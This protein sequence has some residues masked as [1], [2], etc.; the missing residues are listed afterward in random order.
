MR[1]STFQQE[2]GMYF[3]L[4]DTHDNAMSDQRLE[5][6]APADGDSNSWWHLPPGR[7]TFRQRILAI[8]SAPTPRRRSQAAARADAR[9]RR[10]D[11]ELVA[12]SSGTQRVTS[13][14]DRLLSSSSRGGFRAAGAVVKC[15]DSA[16]HASEG[17][18][19]GS[20]PNAIAQS[21]GDV[22]AARGGHGAAGELIFEKGTVKQSE[23]G[24]TAT[25]AQPVVMAGENDAMAEKGSVMR[26]ILEPEFIPET[27]LPFQL[28][29]AQR[30]FD[31]T[32]MHWGDNVNDPVISPDSDGHNATCGASESRCAHI[33]QHQHSKT[34]SLNDIRRTCPLSTGY[35]E[36]QACLHAGVRPAGI[37]MNSAVS[38]SF[39]LTES[40]EAAVCA[41][42]ALRR[43]SAGKA[44]AN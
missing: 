20:D 11:Q 17:P 26:R 32:D 23:T 33:N 39:M 12:T 30:G 41:L 8:L 16:H 35:I 34:A 42:G 44:T 2:E 21:V 3:Y 29:E 9:Q 24:S 43:A 25:A 40:A 27:H 1:S 18:I 6:P 13:A 28:T 14:I 5:A 36:C 22:T 38:H 10:I 7:P 37:D 31:M 4:S 15:A 19:G